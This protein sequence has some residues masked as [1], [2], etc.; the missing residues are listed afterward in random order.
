MDTKSLIQGQSEMVLD[1]L[2]YVEAV[3]ED[4]EEYALALIEEEMKQFNARS[5]KKMPPLQFRTPLM[6]HE[7]GTLIVDDQFVP[8][9]ERSFQPLKIAR[10]TTLDEWKTTAIPQAKSR[11]EAERIRSLVL[12][13]EKEEAVS[14]W[15]DYNT[16][17]EHLQAQASTALQKQREAVEEINYQRQQAQQQQLGPQLDQ[18][19]LEYQQVLYRRNQLQHAIAGLRGENQAIPQQEGTDGSVANASEP[20]S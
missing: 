16:A 19:S 17:L 6:Q 15:K 1:S 7:Y 11:F 8:R 18:L 12:E 4:Y 13:A 9:P 3:H 2:P 10:P 5:L 14:N 20:S